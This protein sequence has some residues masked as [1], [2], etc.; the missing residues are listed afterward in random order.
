MVASRWRTTDFNLEPV[1]KRKNRCS[2][3]ELSGKK[4]KATADSREIFSILGLSSLSGGVGSFLN[5]LTNPNGIEG[6][7]E[8]TGLSNITVEKQE[9]SCAAS[10]PLHGTKRN[11][12]W[13]KKLGTDN[14]MENVDFE[15][16]LS[17][18]NGV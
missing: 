3:V 18:N 5:E 15:R 17:F 9:K 12:Q 10:S 16:K 8:W 1:F 13:R 11:Q 2:T 4:L 14:A 7:K 6:S